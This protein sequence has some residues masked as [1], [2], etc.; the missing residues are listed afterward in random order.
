VN[1]T[2]T[3]QQQQQQ[4]NNN[5]NNNNNTTTTTTTTGPN[6]S[7]IQALKLYM[8]KTKLAGNDAQKS[9]GRQLHED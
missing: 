7:N 8:Y 1:N 6:T 3:Q 5:N 4:H 2:T 9:L